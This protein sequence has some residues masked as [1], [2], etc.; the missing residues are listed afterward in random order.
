MTA[1]TPAFVQITASQDNARCFGLTADGTVWVY[2][3]RQ[4]NQPNQFYR[5]NY[6]PVR[7]WWPTV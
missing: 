4:V 5:T 7:K 2:E 6:V 1:Q 3:I